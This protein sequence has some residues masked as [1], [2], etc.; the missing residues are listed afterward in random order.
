M[1]ITM[2]DRAERADG[3]GGAAS[4]T[5]PRG[6]P[7]EHASIA[8]VYDYWLGG[9]DNTAA[10]RE[11]AEK[12]LRINPDAASL[13]REN[14]AFLIRATRYVALQGI[15]QYL[16]I[17]SGIPTSPNVHE[18]ARSVVQDARVVYVDR[19]PVVLD[20]GRARLEATTNDVAV[21]SGDMRE[22]SLIV[23][24]PALLRLIDF[25]EPVC[26]LLVSVLHFLTLR[27]AETVVARFTEV[28][29]AGSYLVI[30]VGTSSDQKLTERFTTAY[31]AGHLMSHS[32]GEIESWFRGLVLV[33]PGLV[34][35]H[36]W[37]SD[38]SQAPPP[39]RIA[40]VILAGVGRKLGRPNRG[41]RGGNDSAA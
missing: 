6:Q 20:Y 18:V 39:R 13:A 5:E 35:A 27:E 36:Q 25:T 3:S 34:E 26:V 7:I 17:G 4:G 22:P 31:T 16:D 41:G 23:T 9:Q 15:Y 12:L 8:R 38:V 14:R 24:D 33:E 30:S 32:P 10:D 21:V 19:D 29:A 1:E 2:S 37:R 11:L 28:M 40:A